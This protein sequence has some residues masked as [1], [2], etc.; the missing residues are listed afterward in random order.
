MDEAEFLASVAEAA[1]ATGED[2]NAPGPDPSGES[3]DA[4]DG[5]DDPTGAPADSDDAGDTAAGD[6]SIDRAGLAEL[7]TGGD[8]EALCKLAGVDP[9]ILKVSPGKLKADREMLRQAK[10]AEAAAKTRDDLA[11]AKL[12]E[13]KQL[14]D[15][16]KQTY[17]WAVDLKNMIA[18]GDVI[19]VKELVTSLAPKGMTWEQINAAIVKAEK[20]DN[21]SEVMYRA[22]LRKQAQEK[23]EADRLAAEKV[24]QDAEKANETTQAQRNLAS[25]EA[26]LKGT[27]FEKVPRAAETLVQIVQAA[28]DP[29]RKGYSITPQQAIKKL[30]EDPLIALALKAVRGGGSPPAPAADTARR[31]GKGQ[32]VTPQRS[33]EVRVAKKGPAGKE[34]RAKAR[35][36]EFQASIAEASKLEAAERRRTGGP[37]R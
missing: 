20:G 30:A 4:A 17:G 2:D 8:L 36:A 19:G 29:V 37:R 32:F 6:D 33:A 21:P 34:D 5:G 25:A 1:Q 12:T 23:A 13:A 7:L 15:A 14:I 16:G 26:R 11:A 10:T 18:A 35:E 31:N 22:L 3:A 24:R 27:P 9:K 28:Y